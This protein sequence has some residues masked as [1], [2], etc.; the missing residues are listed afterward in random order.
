MNIVFLE[1]KKILFHKVKNKEKLKCKKG[2]NP[3]LEN[4]ENLEEILPDYQEHLSRLKED[5][6]QYEEDL[7]NS[8]TMPVELPY[9]E[10]ENGQEF[11]KK[12][13]LIFTK[14]PEC[15]LHKYWVRDKGEDPEEPQLL[16]IPYNF[17]DTEEIQ[18]WRTKWSR[19][20]FFT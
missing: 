9:K 12:T 16:L 8:V 1:K 11:E 18:G 5:K 7:I 3:F 10:S 19:N 2:K 6:R 20:I 15:K 13:A 4:F 14:E 17:P